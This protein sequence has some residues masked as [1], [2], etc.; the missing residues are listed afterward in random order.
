[1]LCLFLLV[2]L[3]AACV[4][5]QVCAR[6]R[7][8]QTLLF[9][10]INRTVLRHIRLIRG[11]IRA[12]TGNPLPL[13]WIVYSNDSN[14]FKLIWNEYNKVF[15]WQHYFVLIL[16]VPV[17]L[18]SSVVLY[19]IIYYLSSHNVGLGVAGRRAVH[20]VSYE[21]VFYMT[22]SS[23]WLNTPFWFAGGGQLTFSCPKTRKSVIMLAC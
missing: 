22:Y 6:L 16:F 7:P 11:Q 19:Y 23:T 15:L 5:L 21:D 4:S 2:F 8:F 10:A 17:Q 20:S 9:T 18:Q 3:I 14:M 1:M 12:D 13:F